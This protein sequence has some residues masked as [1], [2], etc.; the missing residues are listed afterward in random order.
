[1]TPRDLVGLARQQAEVTVQRT[2]RVHGPEVQALLKSRKP[3]LVC[4]LMAHPDQRSEQRLFRY[5][6]VLGAPASDAAIADWQRQRARCALSPELVDLL[7]RLTEFTFGPTS[8]P[9]E[10]T[11]AFSLSLSGSTFETTLLAPFSA[12]LSQRR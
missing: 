1:M 9:V 5:G 6:H 2:I 11:S 12:M 10:A 4:E 8:T 3:L 7:K